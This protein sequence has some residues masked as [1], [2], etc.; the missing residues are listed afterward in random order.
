MGPQGLQDKVQTPV[1]EYTRPFFATQALATSPYSPLTMILPSHILA[2]LNF[3]C[4][5]EHLYAVYTPVFLCGVPFTLFSDFGGQ[6]LLL[7]K[8]I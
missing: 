4:S 7:F 2:V 8:T 5:P 6:I 3:W 1:H